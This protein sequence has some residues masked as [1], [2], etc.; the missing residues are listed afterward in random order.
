MDPSIAN[1]PRF[2]RLPLPNCLRSPG[3]EMFRNYHYP[4]GYALSCFKPETAKVLEEISKVMV[5]PKPN[6]LEWKPKHDNNPP[7]GEEDTTPGAVCETAEQ[8]IKRLE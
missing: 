5:E 6:G 8:P 2:A 1:D 4:D 7:K 3:L